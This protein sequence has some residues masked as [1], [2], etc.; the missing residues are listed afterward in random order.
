MAARVRDVVPRRLRRRAWA[1]VAPCLR[2]VSSIKG[3]VTDRPI[4]ALTFDDGPDPS[5]TPGV[6]DALDRAGARATFFMLVDRAVAYPDLVA[7]VVGAGHEIALHGLDHTRL[8]SLPAAEVY[9]RSREGRD[10][11]S[12]LSGVP[13]RLFR[14]PHGAQRITTVAA[15]RAAGLV[16]VTWTVDGQDWADHSAEEVADRVGELAGAGAVVVLHD[17]LVLTD[18]DVPPPSA[19]HEE[20]VQAVI[21][22][23]G[24]RGL[25]SIT[26]SELLRSGP[27]RRGLWFRD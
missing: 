24:E 6:L 22:R 21:A 15:M 7:A 8:T 3:A 9:R 18:D 12:R 25:Q 14:A 17:S 26:V 1:T 4:V 11:L 16:P 10:R 23:L 13:V 20:I 19:S 2:G 5:S 27:Q